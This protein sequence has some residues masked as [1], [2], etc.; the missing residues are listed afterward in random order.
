[1]H[2]TACDEYPMLVEPVLIAL[3]G[4]GAGVALVPRMALP[5]P[6][7]TAPIC[8]LATAAPLTRTVYALTRRGR[9]SASHRPAQ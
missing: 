4:A 8:L 5:Q 3:V 2:P 1:V 6:D 7:P 9:W